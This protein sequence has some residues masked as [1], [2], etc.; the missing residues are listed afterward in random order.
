MLVC[1]GTGVAA[2]RVQALSDWKWS[3]VLDPAELAALQAIRTAWNL[4]WDFS[5]SWTGTEL[6]TQGL[7]VGGVS[8]H[9]VFDSEDVFLGYDLDTPGNT[10]SLGLQSRSLTGTLQ[11]ADSGGTRWPE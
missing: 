8:Y 5:K 1:S 3:D 11:R 6:G 7:A 4:P 9:A 10:L 2:S